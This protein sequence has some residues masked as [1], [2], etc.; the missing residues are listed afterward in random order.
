M[1][2][3][4]FAVAAVFAATGGVTAAEPVA[5]PNI[6][7]IVAEDISPNL[8]CYGDPDAI[9]PNLDNFA[10]QGARFTGAFSHAPVCSPSRSGLITGMYPTTMGS[11]HM[12][13]KLVTSPPTF[14]DDLR[15]SGYFVAY[16]GKQ[17]YNF[18]P[19]KGWVDTTED[20]TKKPDVLPKDKPFF[21]YVNLFVTHESQARATKQQYEKNTARLTAEQRRDRAR[22]HLPPYFPDA[23]E[24]RECV[25]KYHENIT[26]MD[27]LV[28]DVLK[29]LDEKKWSENTVVIFFGDHGWGLTRGK[30]WCYDSGTRV[31]FLVRWPEKLKPGSVRDDLTCFLDLA[32]TM[33]SLAGATKPDRMPGRIFL[34]DKTEAAPKYVY[35][36]RDR[37]DET[38][39]RD[40]SARGRR[41][42][43]CKELSPGAAVRPVHQLHGRDAG[44]EGLA[45]ESLCW[46]TRRRAETVLQQDQAR[47][48]TLR[49]GSRPLRGQKPRQGSEACGDIERDAGFG[50]GYPHG[51]VRREG[52]APPEDATGAVRGLKECSL[53]SRRGSWTL[54][55]STGT[56]RYATQEEELNALHN[57]AAP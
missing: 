9:T 11:H 42:P 28:G 49:P 14:V 19:P 50:K 33:L 37:M 46:Q 43:L 35:S 32:P 36:C 13:S 52:E 21:A 29:L 10:S 7:W 31:P 25:A 15:K 48:R 38:Y 39:D 6:V 26:A 18:D 30:R 53:I 57:R 16:P 51:R 1:R 8:G 56:G 34:G 54:A 12:R 40:R 41:F 44:H 27:Y 47:G 5:R 17:D 55:R 20:W 2:G 4:V 45:R 23:P 22:V 24:V 3:F